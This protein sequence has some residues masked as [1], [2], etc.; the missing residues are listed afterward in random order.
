MKIVEFFKKENEVDA[1]Y[2]V[3]E[4]LA[5]F[6]RNDPMFYRKTFFPAMA[7]VSDKLE[8]GEAVDPVVMLRPMVDRGVN[9]YCKKFAQKKRPDD[10]FS[11]ADKI[12]AI[13]KIYSE[14]MPAIKKGDYKVRK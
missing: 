13:K 7:D 5:I 8:R 9:S 1:P 4:D 12:E 6:M 3:V 14:E 10:L 2:N 11:D